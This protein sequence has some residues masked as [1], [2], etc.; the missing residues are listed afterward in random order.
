MTFVT[1]QDAAGETTIEDGIAIAR[2]GADVFR[3]VTLDAVWTAHAAR[4]DADPDALDE[5][6]E[7][8]GRSLQRLREAAPELLARLED[9]GEDELDARLARVPAVDARMDERMAGRVRDRAAR[10]GGLLPLFRSHLGDDGAVFAKEE[11]DLRAEAGR[12]RRGEP[13]D[14]DMS[15]L[16]HC[17]VGLMEMGIGLG[18][19][20]LGL[21]LLLDGAERVIE[22]CA[23]P[24]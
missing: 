4:G 18:S 21:P 14:G 19:A 15:H 7:L 16:T 20:G 13:S 23:E 3:L 6:V 12:I 5:V 11:D 1:P 17:G 24:G 8:M 10:E 2:L 22:H 9:L